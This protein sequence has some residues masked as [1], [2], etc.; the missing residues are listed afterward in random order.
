MFLYTPLHSCTSLCTPVIL[1][2]TKTAR[3]HSQN[4]PDLK[5]VSIVRDR[6]EEA[7][8]NLDLR[9]AVLRGGAMSPLRSPENDLKITCKVVPADD[10][11]ELELLTAAFEGCAQ[12]VL[13]SASH[14]D[15]GAPLDSLE[16]RLG[17]ES[18]SWEGAIRTSKY[19]LSANSVAKIKVEARNVA[20]SDLC[21]LRSPLFARRSSLRSS[22]NARASRR[23]AFEIQA[24]KSAQPERI[25]LRSSMGIDALIKGSSSDAVVRMGGEAALASNRVAEEV[26][27]DLSLHKWI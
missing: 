6:E 5:I 17:K 1:Q 21:S 9:G 4:N 11:K 24:A 18:S 26:S 25:V 12:V 19:T 8:L 23:L 10:P 15:F 16:V 2:Q 7:R 20:K 13:L 22:Q 14:A 3:L 27:E